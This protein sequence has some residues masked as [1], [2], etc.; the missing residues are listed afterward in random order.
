MMGLFFS[1]CNTSSTENLHDAVSDGTWQKCLLVRFHKTYRNLWNT[2]VQLSSCGKL[3]VLAQCV[4][5]TL[6]MGYAWRI[7]LVVKT[8]SP[9]TSCDMP[10]DFHRSNIW[11]KKVILSYVWQSIMRWPSNKK[12]S[13]KAL[14]WYPLPQTKNAEILQWPY[15]GDMYTIGSGGLCGVGGIFEEPGHVSSAAS[16]LLLL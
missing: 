13:S 8:R 16:T 5:E 4:M 1:E 7:C 9:N 3:N 11:Q 14:K 6:F 12:E 2:Y 10:M 15:V